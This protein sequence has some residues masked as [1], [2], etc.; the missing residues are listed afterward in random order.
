[1]TRQEPGGATGPGSMLSGIR[2]LD[3]CR[4]LA[5]PLCSMMLAEHGAEVI[6][7]EHPETGDET[8]SWPPIAGDGFSGY[9]ATMNRGKRGIAVN[10]KHQDGLELIYDI[11]RT[12]DVF[13]QSFTPGVADR[14]GLGYERIS[15][16]NP[17]IVYCSVSGFG[18]TGPYRT[19]R[20]YD[21]ILQAMSGFM[22]VIGDKD[23]GP[24]KSMAPIVDVSTA[25]HAFASILGSLFWRERNG[26]GTGQHIDMSMLDVIVSM[27]SIVGTR[28]LMTGTVPTRQGTENPQRV[29]SAAFECA[30]GRYLQAVPNQRQWPSFCALLEYPEW[31]EDPRFATPVARVNHRDVLYPMV[32]EAFRKRPRDEWRAA[33]DEAAVACAPINDL[34]EVF[35]DPQVQARQ[36][37]E[38]YDQ[39]GVGPVAGLALPF[40]YSQ[41]PCA[42]ITR[43]PELGEHTIDVLRDF[44]RSEETIR[45]L[46]DQGT[47]RAPNR[48]EA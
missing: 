47:V 25:V 32:R 11:A 43:P 15:A 7:V 12:S 27:L 9:F 21:P 10:L 42:T 26:G 28:Y 24:A 6:E 23:G 19:K 8:R 1:V 18:Q 30:D 35:A 34:A 40:K 41:T 29:P 2:V 31:A 45:Q 44:G 36:L 20:G 39:P 38:Y 33:F 48:K 14:L 4:D 22:S 3:V 5:G 37:V 46:L 17:R 16:I 13:M